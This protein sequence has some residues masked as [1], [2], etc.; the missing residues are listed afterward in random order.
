MTTAL[1]SMVSVSQVT[2]KWALTNVRPISQNT[3]FFN[4]NSDIFLTK[5]HRKI[6]KTTSL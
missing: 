5:R 4:I 2:S 3:V 6:E 1:I